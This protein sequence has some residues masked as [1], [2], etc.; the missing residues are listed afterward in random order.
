MW[1]PIMGTNQALHGFVL[2]PRSLLRR[3][4]SH[5][6]VQDV[7]SHADTENTKYQTL[8]CP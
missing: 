6:D 3:N 8:R 1:P 4:A 7:A 5:G 2:L